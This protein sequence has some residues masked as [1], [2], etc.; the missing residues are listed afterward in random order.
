MARRIRASVAS[1]T[2]SR[3]NRVSARARPSRLSAYL[4]PFT[5][6]SAKIAVCSGVSRSWIFSAWP[7]SPLN[8]ASINSAHGAGAT[9]ALLQKA[10]LYD[11]VQ[12]LLN[13]ALDDSFRTDPVWRG[14]TPSHVFAPGVFK[15]AAKKKS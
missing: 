14:L 6:G 7:Q 2:G 5:P 11:D 1:P 9:L 8:T 15:G 12:R 4:A 3:G 13:D 10:E